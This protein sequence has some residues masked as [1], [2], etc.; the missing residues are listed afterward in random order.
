MSRKEGKPI[1]LKRLRK[2]R[3][4]TTKR[5]IL[6]KTL[7]KMTLRAAFKCSLTFQLRM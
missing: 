5:I 2:R 1:R 7:L 4:K 3:K 6:R